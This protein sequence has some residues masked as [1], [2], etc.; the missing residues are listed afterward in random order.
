MDYFYFALIILRSSS[1]VSI[2][3]HNNRAVENT[4]Q[5]VAARLRLKRVILALALLYTAEQHEFSSG[6]TIQLSAAIIAARL[7]LRRVILALALLYR[8]GQRVV[9]SGP[10]IQLGSV[11]IAARLR[12]KRVIVA[13]ALLHTSVQR[14][15][16][17]GPT[18][19]GSVMVAARLQLGREM[20]PSPYTDSSFCTMNTHFILTLKEARGLC[21]EKSVNTKM[22][23]SQDTDNYI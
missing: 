13:L 7:R 5:S 15:L 3:V 6:P 17:R 2:L 10:T 4:C 8:A 19:F 16:F 9:S 23:S 18:Q 1:Y 11:L 21:L 14:D 12:L 20:F 22:E